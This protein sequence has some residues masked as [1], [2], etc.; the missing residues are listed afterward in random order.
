MS[1]RLHVGRPGRLLAAQRLRCCLH[2]F[3]EIKVHFYSEEN[4]D[5]LS[6]SSSGLK[7]PLA[8]T[9]SRILFQAKSEGANYAQYADCAPFGNNRL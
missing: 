1:R 2:L 6:H 7:G 5:R 9:F 8:E 4:I 3:S